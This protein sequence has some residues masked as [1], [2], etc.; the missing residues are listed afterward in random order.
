MGL[1]TASEG[2]DD[3]RTIKLNTKKIRPYAYMVTPD[4]SLK[5]GEYAFVGATG[6]GGSAS[7]GSVVIF[8]FGIDLK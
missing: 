6:V 5:P 7:S 8:D 2:N 3:K 1:G 4:I